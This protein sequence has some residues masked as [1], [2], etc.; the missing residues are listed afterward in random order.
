MAVVTEERVEIPGVAGN[1]HTLV[2]RPQGARPGGPV[3]VAWSDIFQL[4]APH[5]RLM[6][7][8]ASRGYTVV[9]PE[10]YGRIEPGDT[11][12]D[13][14]RDRQRALDDAARLQLAWVDEDRRAVL[15]HARG[16][17]DPGRLGVCGF[18][19]GGHLAFRAAAEPGVRAAACFYATGVHS[20]TLGAA[21]GTAD[22]LARAPQIRGELL[23]LWGAADPHIPADGRRRIHRALDDAG[24]RF[25]FRLYDAEHAFLRDEGPRFDPAAADLAFEAAASLFARTL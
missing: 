10:L 17:G 8:L 21:Q 5:V 1:I 4:T 6:K 12:L 2:L 24:V 11:P 15:D 13:F 7:R 25:E 16:L 18:C 19:F 9:T 20:D 22:T 23:L 3:V 14:D